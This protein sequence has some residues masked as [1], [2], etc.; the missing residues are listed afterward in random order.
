MYSWL[1]SRSVGA[2]RATTRKTRGLT[3]S[4]IARI[5]PPLPAPSRP[6]K[7]ITTR[8]FFSLTHSC[9][10]HI[11]T[12][13]F[14]SDFSYSLRFIVFPRG[15]APRTPLHRR[16]LG[17]SPPRSAPVAHSLRSFAR[18]ASLR[19]L[20]RIASLRSLASG[21]WSLW[22]LLPLLSRGAA[23]FLDEIEAARHRDEVELYD[24][25]LGRALHDGEQRR[26]AVRS[27]PPPRVGLGRPPFVVV[28]GRVAL[29][30]GGA[31][32]TSRFQ[33]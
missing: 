28:D 2:G 10:W 9:R 29:R 30:P 24:R 8:S 31:V 6:S 7:R 4:V 25:R 13:S 1:F 15:F 27:H 26:E 14:S 11:S 17:A 12:C 16:S 5:V 21:S 32:E 20:A 22:S 3:R 33:P 18:I 23:D 19:S